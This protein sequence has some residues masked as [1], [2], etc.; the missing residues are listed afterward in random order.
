M[1]NTLKTYLT[2]DTYKKM[3][4][5]AQR[6]ASSPRPR[7]S[8]KCYRTIKRD[9]IGRI[10]AFKKYQQQRRNNEKSG[11][12][13]EY[14]SLDCIGNWLLAWNVVGGTSLVITKETINKNKCFDINS[15]KVN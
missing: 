7:D 10:K 4:K 5:L 8:P 2:E 13:F 15:K 3:N 12:I 6:V 9:A 14:I 1:T 11:Y